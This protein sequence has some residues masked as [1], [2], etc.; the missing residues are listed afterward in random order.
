MWSAAVF[1]QA[2]PGRRLAA[3]NSVVL[4][5]H[6]PCWHQWGSLGDCYDNSMIESFWSRMQV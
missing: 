1:D 4:S 3:R 5:H 6:S 2:L